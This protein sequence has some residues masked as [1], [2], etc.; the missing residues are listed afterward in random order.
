M[1]RRS[2]DEIA[3]QQAWDEAETLGLLLYR[4]EDA[5]RYEEMRRASESEW[6]ILKGHPDHSSVNG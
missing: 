3:A 5:Q 6:D 4:A 2:G 1:H